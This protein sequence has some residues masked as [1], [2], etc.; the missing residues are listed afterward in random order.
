MGNIDK[1]RR[2][3]VAAAAMLCLLATIFLPGM[4]L[5]AGAASSS[6]AETS[7][8]SAASTAS[9]RATTARIQALL[10]D[11]VNGNVSLPAGTF[12]IRPGLRLHQGETITGHRTTLKVASGS[13]NY[14][15]VLSGAS[16]AT[17]LSGLTIT[18]V[19]FDQNWT[20][21]PI[22]RVAAL[23]HGS[24][25]FVLLVGRGSYITIAHNRFVGANNINTV[26]TGGATSHVTISGNA[27]RTVNTPWHDHSSVYTSGTTTVITRNTF[28]GAAAVAA[29]IEVHGTRV[30][31]TR[32]DVRGYYRAVNVVSHYTA[33]SHNT[34]IGAVN[35][36]DL[37]STVGPGLHD[38]KVTYNVLN[39]DLAHWARVLAHRGGRL[40]PPRYTKQVIKDA[41]SRFP[42]H[43]IA[44]HG[45]RG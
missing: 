40:P 22:H 2:L 4:T 32:N 35:P 17:D 34:V 43:R 18:G 12:A 26:V 38:V 16:L 19:T 3:A 42:L 25:R 11:P 15:A 6:A 21:N 7:T 8:T 39:R 41:T 24:P 45:N 10:D 29:A 20:G 36:V 5:A 28:A 27:F 13:G 9:I 1:T 14:A 37:W 33:V 30:T 31:V 23:Y 44:I